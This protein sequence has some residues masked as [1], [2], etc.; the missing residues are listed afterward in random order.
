VDPLAHAGDLLR[1]VADALEIG[2][3]LGDR[4]DEAQVVRRR[5]ALDDDVA[6]RA[7]EPKPS[8]ARR[9]CDS[10]RPPISRTRERIDSSSASNCLERCSLTLTPI[11]TNW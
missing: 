2:D 5:L 10:T 4:E 7:V 11:M 1:L 8:N 3:G 6:A 9:I